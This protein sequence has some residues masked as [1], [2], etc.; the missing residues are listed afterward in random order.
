MFLNRVVDNFDFCPLV[1]QVK[2]LFGLDSFEQFFV[3]YFD[4][5][6]DFFFQFVLVCFYF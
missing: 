1:F 3:F 6:F 2:L 5:H 4:I